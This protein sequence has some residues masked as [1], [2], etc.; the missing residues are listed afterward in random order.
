MAIIA[1]RYWILLALAAAAVASYSVGFLVG[2]WALIAAG[3]V[4]EL[5]F[6]HQLV[7]RWRR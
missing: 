7:K 4:F 6:W 3:V 5:A 2:F 1:N